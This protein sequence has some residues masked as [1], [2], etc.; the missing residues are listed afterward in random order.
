MGGVQ[1]SA[2]AEGLKLDLVSEDL[3]ISRDLDSRAL[4]ARPLPVRRPLPQLHWPGTS[5]VFTHNSL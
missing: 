1:G 5:G 4:S 3:G 2:R